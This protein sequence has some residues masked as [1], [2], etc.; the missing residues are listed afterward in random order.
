MSG[1]RPSHLLRRGAVYAVRFRIPADLK[2]KIGMAEFTRS[3]HTS[4]P[5]EART[6]CLGAT[7]WFRTA[8]VRLRQMPA[9]SRTDLEE[10]ARSLFE[11]L[12]AEH[13]RPR[14][15][16]REHF[17]EDVAWNIECSK[18]RIRALDDQLRE[19]IFDDAVKLRAS[20]LTDTPHWSRDDFTDRGLQL[21][22]ALTARAERE[23]LHRFIEMLCRPH[24]PPAEEDPLFQSTFEQVASPV[25]S[26]LRRTG[27]QLHLTVREAVINYLNRQTARNLG[28]S[29]NF[30]P[31]S[32]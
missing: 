22:Q 4:D 19:G 23:H 8:I 20:H 13:D 31:F 29:Q 2:A 15:F 30:R 27:Q 12:A 1:P 32:T 26:G 16:D 18:D 25:P 17:D 10:A 9:P 24:R 21:A 3:L 14:E 7:V 28:K 6:R 5:A 11:K